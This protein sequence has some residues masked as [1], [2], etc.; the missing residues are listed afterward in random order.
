MTI[1]KCTFSDLQ[2]LQE[3]SIETFSDTFKD[4]NPP[5]HLNAYLEK[6]YNL[7]Q[8][9]HEITNPSSHFFFVY[10]EQEVAGY[11][12]VNTADAQSE[13]MGD[14]ALEV[15]R[16]YVRKKFQKLGLGKLLL[17]KA[18]EMA[19]EQM[20]K[21]IW[22]GVWEDNENAIAFYKKKGF[23]QTGSHSFYMGEDE[24]VDL[25]MTKTLF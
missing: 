19:A 17:D 20:K 16:I 6:A 1:K 5:E 23:V 15:E 25:I 11:L 21:K 12:K 9:E 4:Q 22:L 18:F 2:T 10:H 3:I 13:P 24:Q 8:L 7:K 14:D